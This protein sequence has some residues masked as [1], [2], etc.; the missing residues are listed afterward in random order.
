M[1]EYIMNKHSMK[2]RTPAN[3]QKPDPENF[4]TPPSAIVNWTTAGGA[5]RRLTSQ[6]VPEC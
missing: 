4:A 2:Q 3:K 5:S 1:R 6:K